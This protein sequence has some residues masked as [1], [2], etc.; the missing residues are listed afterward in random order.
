MLVKVGDTHYV[1]GDN[2]HYT[3][4]GQEDCRFTFDEGEVYRVKRLIIAANG[5]QESTKIPIISLLKGATGRELLELKVLY[6]VAESIARREG[7][8]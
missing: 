3:P 1:E 5:S 2:H 4:I 6:E 7:S 8:I